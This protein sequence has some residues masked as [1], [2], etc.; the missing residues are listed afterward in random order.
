MRK[1]PFTLLMMLMAISL[2]QKAWSQCTPTNCLASLPAYGGI[3]DTV[4]MNGTVNVAYSDFESFH[5]TTACFD[6]GIID[7]AQAGQN[8]TIDVIDNFTFSGLPAGVTATTNATSYTSPANGCISVSGTPTEAGLF[9][10][11]AA[12]EAD[13]T[14]YIGC[15]FPILSLPDNAASYALELLI[16]PDPSF[17]IPATTFGSCD[18]AVM[19]TATGTT[20]GT[21]SGPGVSG[22]MFDPAAAGP[23]THTI[24]YVV[25]AQQGAAIAPAA[26]S[27]TLT[28]TVTSFSLTAS[29]T[30]ATCTGGNG[31]ATVSPSGG[32]APYTYLW[33]NGATSATANNLT[34]GTYSVTVTDNT[35]CPSDATVTVSANNEVITGA[36]TTTNAGCGLSDG[37]AT[38]TPSNGTAPYTYIWTPSAQTTQT[39]NNLAAG[40]YSVTIT[41]ANGCE[42]T[43]NA[44]VNNPNSPTASI[45]AST[46]VACNGGT[47]GDATVAGSGGTTPYTYSWSSGGTSVTETGLAAGVYDVTIVDAASC[48]ATSSVTI[49]EPTALTATVD[50]TAT[51][52][53]SCN[54]G[55][56]GTAG[57]TAAGGTAPYAY[58]WSNSATTATISGV[59]AGNYVVTITDANGCETSE[60][61]SVGEPTALA[62][63]LTATDVT[64][65]GSVDGSASATVSGGTAPYTYSWSNSETSANIS[66]LA[67][68]NYDLTVTDAN[69]CVLTPTSVTVS[70][71]TA[72]SAGV[73]AT[74]A[75]TAGGNDGA[76][77]IAPA[78][79][80]APYNFVWS[81]GPLTEDISG[82]V[83]GTYSV[84]ITDANGCT[85][86]VSG[87][88]L[89]GPSSI[90]YT[91]AGV[92]VAVYPNPTN[93]QAVLSL[94]ANVA[95][96]A[97]VQI[98]NV[99]GQLVENFELNNATQ[100]R[101][102][103]DLT[104]AAAGVYFVR[105]TI[106]DEIIVQRVVKQ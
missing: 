5:T 49:T 62:A 20:G 12:F 53:V 82:V 61:I 38:A 81:N 88:V 73:T 55:N 11:T 77:D 44:T 6:A 24:S 47:T 93:G 8:I 15:A 98:T 13:V 17:S 56:D 35:G 102:T 92:K 57:I 104:N 94:E 45:T 31:S 103:I 86:V 66:G 72:I 106:G 19:L 105:V 21:F 1:L 43:L 4:L 2:Q 96:D 95:V 101:H 27:S 39:A 51:N 10:A 84:T 85:H 14:A 33:S 26:D 34:A 59:T 69:G 30:D 58:A 99:M 25:S 78:G 18:A 7:P 75:S 60:N 100:A 97:Q 16:L 74:D 29:S 89:D 91:D 23:G 22:N 80:T 67:A 71:P 40:I 41:D 52:D 70:E 87:T 54:A 36:T 9:A 68:G 46:N 37:S 83:A 64:C 76:V 50:A 32:S 63:N 3:C 48:V 28:V 90:G 65:N 79:G 42:G